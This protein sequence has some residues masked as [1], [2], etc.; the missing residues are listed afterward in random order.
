MTKVL[1][2][3]TSPCR[4]VNLDI[5]QVKVRAPEAGLL[6]RLHLQLTS[7]VDRGDPRPALTVVI[8]LPLLGV[9]CEAHKKR[10]ISQAALTD[11]GLVLQIPPA[12]SAPQVLIPASTLGASPGSFPFVGGPW[13]LSC[14]PG[15]GTVKLELS[16]GCVRLTT[17]SVNK[18]YLDPGRLSSLPQRGALTMTPKVWIRWFDLVVPGVLDLLRAELEALT[19]LDPGVLASPHTEEHLEQMTGAVSRNLTRVVHL[20]QAP[21]TEPLLGRQTLKVFEFPHANY[22]EISGPTDALLDVDLPFPNYLLRLSEAKDSLDEAWAQLLQARATM[23]TAG[24]W[25]RTVKETRA[26]LAEALR[27]MERAADLYQQAR[28]KDRLIP[29]MRLARQELCKIRRFLQ[30]LLVGDLVEAR[31]LPRMKGWAARMAETSDLITST[32]R[33]ERGRLMEKLEQLDIFRANHKGGHLT[34]ESG[35]PTWQVA[36]QLNL[37]YT[38]IWGHR[39][40]PSLGRNVTVQEGDVRHWI[41]QAG[42]E[43]LDTDEVWRVVEAT[44]YEAVR[45]HRG[46]WKNLRWKIRTRIQQ[47]LK[48]HL[49]E[50]VSLKLDDEPMAALMVMAMQL[51]G[52]DLQ[53]AVMGA[54]RSTP[55]AK[56]EALMKRLL[57]KRKENEDDQD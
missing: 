9:T 5:S 45:G 55:R 41:Q 30:E 56:M 27:L 50:P 39:V 35:S 44:V 36:G 11:D 31:A 6:G 15:A 23:I 13:Q 57:T 47:R 4:A 34:L 46:D 17:H 29:G 8:Q 22:P 33:A 3:P 21:P 18:H 32:M 37:L 12:R 19:A 43:D 52:V 14:V 49:G 1:H 16:S 20:E 28:G 10:L 24:A 42:L 38:A 26:D 40:V 48:D 7:G 2:D 51:W 54:G 25:R 53:S